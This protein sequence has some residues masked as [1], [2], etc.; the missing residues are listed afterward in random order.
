MD[1]GRERALARIATAHHGVF[2]RR[3]AREVGFTDAA[4]RAR[5]EAGAWELVVRGIYRVGAA[6]P[7]WRGSLLAAIW[8]GGPVA[9]ASHRAA[10][11]LYDLPGG[12]TE[13]IELTCR[14]W[15]RAHHQPLAVHESKVLQPR[16]IRRIDSI[17]VT[18]PAWTLLDVAGLGKPRLLEMVFDAAER[19][20]LVTAADADA[21]LGSVAC[22]GR[23]GVR[24][25][26]RSVARRVPGRAIPESVMETLL[27]E[28]LRAHGLPDPVPQHSIHA[29][30][31]FVARVDAAYPQARVA[32]EYESYEHHAIRGALVRDHR[33]RQAII[34]AG[35]LPIGATYPDLR[36]GGGDLVRAIRTSL[37]RPA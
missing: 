27:L 5:L 15:L 8:A 12:S 4:I 26:R 3:H 22:R 9:A 17:P 37:S 7:S 1:H 35:W 23:R 31:R 6:P 34:A 2:T 11:S 21:F 16:F 18:C 28:V 32:I 20:N 29:A 24:L 10:L 36:D 19:K 14:R 30:G 33:R 25:L 13:A